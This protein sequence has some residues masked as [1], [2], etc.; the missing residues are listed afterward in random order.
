M[1]VSNAVETPL[2]AMAQLAHRVR[3]C[4]MLLSEPNVRWMLPDHHCPW[5]QRLFCLFRSP[6]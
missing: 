4:L 6:E 2:L 1:A 3:G 5:R